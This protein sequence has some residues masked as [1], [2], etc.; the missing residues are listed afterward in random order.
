MSYQDVLLIGVL[1]FPL[2]MLLGM[3]AWTVAGWMARLEDAWRRHRMDRE[4]A[5]D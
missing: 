4:H 1:A 2:G 5:H 3:A